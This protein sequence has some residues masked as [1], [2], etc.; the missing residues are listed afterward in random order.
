MCSNT[1]ESDPT[2]IDGC[3]QDVTELSE[4][5]GQGGLKIEREL[6]S[7]NCR[8]HVF[9]VLSGTTPKKTGK[10]PAKK[11]NPQASLLSASDDFDL[12]S[13]KILI[14]A[15]PFGSAVRPVSM[16]LTEDGANPTE[17][18]ISAKVIPLP[19]RSLMRDAHEFMA[20]NI[21]PA[22]QISQRLPVT[23]FRKNGDM[24]RPVDMP[25]DLDTPGKR[26]AWWRK[27]RGKTLAQVGAKAKCS[28]GALNDFERGRS[29]RF[30]QLHLVCA[31]LKLNAFYV[32]SGRGEPELEYEQE[33]AGDEIWPLP[34][35]KAERVAKLD[36][37]SKEL[38]AYKFNEILEEIELERRRQRRSPQD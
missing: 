12:C 9:P 33:P 34:G 4:L 10:M 8:N 19:R 26:I 35:V 31:Y 1:G 6:D 11:N 38:A 20:P 18:P 2:A 13:S 14:A 5:I 7:G 36:P 17:A 37:I 27:H 22:V 28:T 3:S 15:S 23:E 29:Q 25:S 32:D 16:S 21:R 30:E 24:P